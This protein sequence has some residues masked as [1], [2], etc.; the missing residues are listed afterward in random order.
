MEINDSYS[1]QNSNINQPIHKIKTIMHRFKNNYNLVLQDFN[2]KYP[3]CV[4][5]L[6][7]DYIKIVPASED[8]HR[9]IT[10]TLKAKG[11]EFYVVPTAG[12]R[13]YKVVL[14][15]ASTD[16]ADIKNDLA[17]QE[18]TVC[19][20]SQLTQWKSKFLL[21]MVLVEVRK[22]VPDNRDILDI[23]NC[24]YM[25]I[26]RDSFRRRPGPTQ[27]YNCNY[28][29]HSSQYCEIKTRCLKCTQEHRTS[30]CPIKERIENHECINCKTHGHTANSKQCP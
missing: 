10:T 4:N 15:P 6:I 25:S 14:K 3:D 9:K 27:C 13:P 28:F 26:A 20:V 5:K 2:D 29:H 17:N 18:V 7:G 21:P 30:D 22:N 19:K 8:Q 11:D 12:E 1:N 24:C 23:S 16:I